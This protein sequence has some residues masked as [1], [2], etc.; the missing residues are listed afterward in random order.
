[1]NEELKKS[2][3]I[4]NKEFTLESDLKVQ[5]E[6]FEYFNQ[7]FPQI[8][9]EEK[10][11]E[12]ISNNNKEE[13]EEEEEDENEKNNQKQP[14]SNAIDLTLSTNNLTT[15]LI[16]HWGIFPINKPKSWS[17]PSKD[18]YPKNSIEFDKNALQTEFSLNSEK[19][20]Q[21]I[22]LN[23][24]KNDNYSG[25]NFV[26]YSPTS[27]KWYNNNHQ[28]YQ[29]K[30][31]ENKTEKKLTDGLDIPDF[32]KDIIK[33]ESSN[34]GWCLMHRFNKCFDII[35]N[36]NE[37]TDN[38]L[39]SWIFIWLRYSAQR[40]LTWERNYGTRPRLLSEA[41]NRLSEY[42]TRIYSNSVKT[43]K[44]YENLSE[45]KSFML[46]GILA[47]LGKGTGNGQAIR[48][49]ILHIMRRLNI[50]SNPINN[51][52]EQWHQ[53]LHN[54][55]TPD[56]IIICEGL[57]KFLKSNNI[58]DYRNYLR[59]RGVT[60]EVLRS[61]RRK[62]ENEPWHNYGY[63]GEFENYLKILKSVHASNDLVM[64][65][66]ECRNALGDKRGVFEEIIKCKDDNN[67]LNQIGRVTNGR[68]VLYNL[69]KNNLNDIFKLR[70]FLFLEISLESYVRQ[71]VEK[72]L[73]IKL[74]M[75]QYIDEI[76]LILRNI[77]VSFP[78]YSEFNLC[79]S[80]WWNIVEKHKN[81][82]SIDNTLKIKSVLGRLSRLLSN[83]ID[84]YNKYFDKQGKIFGMKCNVDKFYCD[85]FAEELIRGSIFFTLSVL[86]KE[87]EP[88]IRKNAHLN[89]WIIISRGI[90]ENYYGKLI[91]IKNLQ[92]VQFEKYKEKTL[93][94]SENINGEEEIPENCVGL[95][96]INSENY[97]D[98]LSHV[99]VRAR[100]LNVP[101]SVCFNHETNE[102]NLK[103]VNN[104][105]NLK[106]LNDKFEIEKIDNNNNLEENN[107]DNQNEKKVEIIDVGDKYENIFIELND[108][109]KNNVGAKS[110][111]TKKIYKKIPNIESWINY[112]ESFSIPFN[113][114]EYFL[115]LEQNSDIKEKISKNI[116]KIQNS[117]KK[118]IKIK[119]LENCKDLTKQIKFIENSETLKLKEKIINFGVKNFDQAFSA[120]KSVWASK[121]NQ[122]AFIATSKVG[123]SLNNIKMAVLCQKII[124]SEY[125]F[126]I[127]TKNPLNND[128]NELFA[129]IVNGMGESLV[130]AYEGTSFSFV[131]NKL[132]GNYE[133][134]SYQNKSI[135]LKNEGFIF[136]SDSNTEDLE[137]FSGA[138]LFDSV[139]MV[140]DNKIEINYS[141]DKL[142][143]DKNFNSF[144][145]KKISELGI[146]VEKLF[147]GVPQDI[148]GVYYND[149][150]YIV[151][152]RPQV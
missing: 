107:K 6:W 38:S 80:D 148:E 5:I 133:I 71:L 140:E 91:F 72:I 7:Q 100:N 4:K 99:S 123:I 104:Y 112:P 28:D 122:R 88:I 9:E 27:N 34:C 8:K 65:F 25:I 55:T 143:N 74:N 115:N 138:G 102:N 49:E 43:E 45:C 137:G 126:V 83:I 63:I 128:K 48:D 134:K 120:I 69:I 18:Y 22:N 64:M 35:K 90:K 42:V 17:H 68:E 13:E 84:F 61:Y 73:H 41:M 37:N 111:N 92:E 14:P 33:I 40:Q 150:F 2:V 12:P 131:Y 109:S 149:N 93:I 59:E 127:H 139:P 136:R 142:F 47:Q 95:I 26:F 36:F 113:V 106:I 97:P 145:I 144:M 16:F 66:E 77:K 101:F 21:N 152:T 76:S 129:E 15:K 50:P 46:K 108:F 1:M 54:N 103:L 30:F 56:D 141:N 51:F 116:E 130:G 24:P 147:E 96:I 60:P 20:N 87:I 70:D 62:I 118:S 82:T 110:N 105:V 135:C 32:A 52:Y 3:K 19:T 53:K 44:N 121:F 89:D 98:V 67:V 29:I 117:K 125:A 23:L 86:L 114:N 81:D 78:N 146:N 132:N 31:I 11:K 39:W 151:Q 79:Y 85:L 58:E 119:L 124:P 94:L 10:A 57:I 75:Q